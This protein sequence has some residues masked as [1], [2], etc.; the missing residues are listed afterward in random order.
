MT[1]LSQLGPEALAK[2]RAAA[3]KLERSAY[4]ISKDVYGATSPAEHMPSAQGR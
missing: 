4:K 1:E 3:L 2:A